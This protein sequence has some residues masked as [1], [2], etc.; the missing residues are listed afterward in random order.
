[1]HSIVIPS[2]HVLL[3]FR[4]VLTWTL[5]SAHDKAD[6]SCCEG[7]AWDT[8]SPRP[9]SRCALMHRD[10]ALSPATGT[11]SCTGS[12]S[13][14]P[15]VTLAGSSTHGRACFAPTS[16]YPTA[17]HTSITMSGMDCSFPSSILQVTAPYPTTIYCRQPGRLHHVTRERRRSPNTVSPGMYPS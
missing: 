2:I 17:L 1:M 13:P 10:C 3:R 11:T 14:P 6:A 5:L 8:M 12:S 16:S 15:N 4:D 7:W 9:R